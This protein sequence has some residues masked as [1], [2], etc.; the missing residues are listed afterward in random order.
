MKY[1]IRAMKVERE[2][3][4][5]RG[6]ASL[7]F[8]EAF[9]INQ[10][11]IVE[12]KE[13]QL[14]VQM[15]SVRTGERD[16]QSRE[17]YMNVAHPITSDFAKELSEHILQVF[18]TIDREEPMEAAFENDKNMTFSARIT[19]YEHSESLKGTATITF[20]GCFTVKNVRILEGN[21]GLY[22]QM[23]SYRTKEIDE[24]QRPIYKDYAHPI[25]AE[26]REVLYSALKEDYE[27]VT[28]KRMETE[29]PDMPEK[30][31]G[32]EKKRSGR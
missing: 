8:E 1:K 15:P 2:G 7:V 32:K 10:I 30:E 11:S 19:P 14:Y 3:S 4:F 26:F 17:V 12:G 22:I 27:R 25:T 21:N 23:P 5:V 20:A 9:A 31:A 18:S 16:M 13:G 28:Q 29:R 24:D 6:V